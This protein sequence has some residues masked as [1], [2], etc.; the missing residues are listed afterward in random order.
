ML[1]ISKNTIQGKFDFDQFKSIKETNEKRIPSKKKLFFFIFTIIS[2][3]LLLAP[4]TQNI[5]ATG[6]LTSLN[7]ATRPQTIHSVIPGR[8]ENWMVAEGQFV[9][10]NDTVAILSEIKDSYFNPDLISNLEKQ[11]D[12]K[13]SGLGSYKD[14]VN[15]L[16]QQVKALELNRKLKKESLANKIEQAKLKITT[17]SIDL[18]AFQNN[19]QI[20]INQ[21]E[22]TK[23][24]HKEGL[25]SLTDLENKNLKYQEDLAKKIAQENKF[26][27]SKN[28]LLNAKIEYNNIDN[29]F[30]DK[31]AK[32]NSDKFTAISTI[33]DTE[34]QIVKLENDYANYSIRAEK[35]FILAPQDGYIT[36]AFVT[37][38]GQNIKEGEPLISILPA[39]VDMAV[40]LFVKPLDL[41]LL[42]VGNKVRLQFDG[43]PALMFSG[44]QGV[45]F[46]T[47]GGEIVAIDNFTTN[48]NQY[49]ILV[50]PDKNS[51]PWPES[52]KIGSG[53][54]GI[55]MLKNVPIYY[56]IWRQINGFPPEYYTN[57]VI[58][59]KEDSILKKIK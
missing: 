43:W 28:E 9:K 12:T 47:F 2:I 18:I 53:A 14:K 46:G 55:V 11:I 26:L 34:S 52:I 37:G 17:D 8:I 20:S 23:S 22:R 6:T 58:D 41:P 25:K 44:W 3:A 36:K 59:K 30:N 33:Y 19:L 24:L 16:D 13:E 31:I 4:W 1:N 56:E 45:S 29:E 50:S 21:L 57:Q 49:R 10:K 38:I 48:T 5:Q 40:E 32:T 39:N 51:E 27:L 54:L 42:K 7:P 35:Y 15:A